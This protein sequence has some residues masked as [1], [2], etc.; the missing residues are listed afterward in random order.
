MFGP[1]VDGPVT[2]TGPVV[3]AS[4][5]SHKVSELERILRANQADWSLV[6]LAEVAPDLPDVVETGVTFE[7][8]SLLKARTVSTATGMPALADDSGLCVDV[9]NGM[10]GLFSARWSGQHG[11]DTGNLAL[12]LAQLA[13]VPD[14]LRTAQFVCVVTLVLPDGRSYVGRG[15]VAGCL[16][17]GPRGSN[18]FG[19]DPIFV[20]EGHQQTTAEIA[21]QEKDQLSHRSRAVSALVQSVSGVTTN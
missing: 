9:L 3:V 8:N 5:N 12:L 10:P 11:D 15:E 20:P 2:M 4:R 16:T 14:H 1:V 21:P 17:R 18:G 7:E 19:Y 13:D 6:N